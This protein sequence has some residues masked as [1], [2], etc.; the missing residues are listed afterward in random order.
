MTTIYTGYAVP[1][2]LGLV[3]VRSG[4][5]DGIS[6]SSVTVRPG[7][8]LTVRP[9]WYSG[10]TGCQVQCRTRMRKAYAVGLLD[11]DSGAEV[12]TDFPEW[13]TPS[14]ATAR[15]YV[16]GMTYQYATAISLQFGSALDQYDLYEVEIRARVYS[17]IYDR[18]SD[19]AYGTVLVAPC[20]TISSLTASTD[21]SGRLVVTASTTQPRTGTFIRMQGRRDVI[22]GSVAETNEGTSIT[23]DGNPRQVPSSLLVSGG[24]NAGALWCRDAYV[25]RPDEVNA[26]R[27]EGTNGG[28]SSIAYA[29][30]GGG[31]MIAPSTHVDP[32]DVPDP[33]ISVTTTSTA[34]VVV[35]ISCA[36]DS[37]VARAEYS[38]ADGNVFDDF[39]SIGGSSP[40]W[41]A[42][43]EDP[44]LGVDM[45][46][47]AACCNA[48]GEYKLATA[49]VTAVYDSHAMLD[50]GGRHIELR[51]EGEFS[52][53]SEPV[54]E[55]IATA[56]RRLPVSRH[57]VNVSRTMQVKGTIA[58][59]SVFAFGDMELSALDALDEPHDW[60]FR[61]PRGVR[62]RVR[63]T[64]W[65]TSQDTEQLGRL[66]EVS[67][68]MEEVDG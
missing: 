35:S 50:G 55:S 40:S 56:G 64:G 25:Y 24:A 6:Q 47:K 63:V 8:T 37:V 39:L 51:Y 18:C 2:Q 65:N 29:G 27:V 10:Y 1:S 58:F 34:Q 12:W 30:T 57:G 7:E 66:A 46:V 54:G 49:T 36:C 14:G 26:T 61:N 23:A 52:Q 67:I 38:D 19:W 53:A 4:A 22:D 21:A 9:A 20:P 43:L 11:D 68:D 13:T 28:C 15:A 31:Y 17:A 48:S 59:P 42:V 44:P 5:I 41:T 45:T 3:T 16:P 33:S 60:L 62:K 32:Q